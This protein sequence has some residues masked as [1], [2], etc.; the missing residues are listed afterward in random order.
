MLLSVVVWTCT[1][2]FDFLCYGPIL[3]DTSL[4]PIWVLSC[5]QSYVALQFSLSCLS[6]MCRFDVRAATGAVAYL[7]VGCMF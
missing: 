7:R 4:V 6:Y 2:L 3:L 5:Y 1:D